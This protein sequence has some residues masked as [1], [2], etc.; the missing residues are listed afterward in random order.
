LKTPRLG[1]KV[2]IRLLHVDGL[3]PPKMGF[4]WIHI[5]F[6]K[7]VGDYLLCNHKVKYATDVNMHFDHNYD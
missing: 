3:T 2:G 1:P 7:L 6:P 5:G 4:D